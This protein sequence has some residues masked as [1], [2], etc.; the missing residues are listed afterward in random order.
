[1]KRR[2]DLSGN[3]WE[4]IR[5]MILRRDGYRCADCGNPGRMEVHHSVSPLISPELVY[6][7]SNLRSLCRS[8]HIDLHGRETVHPEIQAWREFVGL[9]NSNR[10]RVS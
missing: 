10:L 5:K 1:M 6:E 4:R 2:P 7:P 3:R 9:P 8:C